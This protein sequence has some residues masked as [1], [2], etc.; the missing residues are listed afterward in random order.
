M[1]TLEVRRRPGTGAEVHRVTGASATV[2]ASSGNEVVVRA[3]GVYGRHVRLFERDGRYHLDLFKGIETVQVN[4]RD[5]FGGAIAAGD[6]ITIGEATI[7][8]VDVAPAG[9]PAAGAEG[10]PMG[11][12]LSPVGIPGPPPATPGVITIPVT[13]VEYRSLRQTAYRICR[14]SGSPEDLA[15][16]LTDFLDRELP[17]SEWAVGEFTAAAGFRPL[18]STF[19]ENPMLPPRM[20]QDLRSGERLSRAETVTGTLTLVV[21]PLT[22]TGCAGILVRESPRLAAR[23]VLFLEELVQIAGLAF[24]GMG[25][26]SASGSGSGSAESAPARPAA[27]AAAPVPAPAESSPAETVLRQTDDLKKIVETVE[28]EVIDRAMR[29]VEGNQSRAAQILN[30]SR[31]SLIAKLKEFAIPDY[32]YLR[33]ERGRRG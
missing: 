33:R 2:G 28:R 9:R 10:E 19:R 27:E 31:G 15:T 23:A 7:T 25:Q 29:R 22:E 12:T 18:A 17:P 1:L 8:V 13:E 5:F 20:T 14:A 21:E 16:E 30:I 3:R 4:G 6:R 32:R 26:R 11:D 24:A